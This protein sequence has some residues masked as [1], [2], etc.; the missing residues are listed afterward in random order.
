M[1][2]Q[3]RCSVFV[4]IGRRATH[5][6]HRGVVEQPFSFEYKWS[7]TWAGVGRRR[8]NHAVAARIDEAQIVRQTI[9]VDV[10]ES[11][12]G[13]SRRYPAGD[14]IQ[15]WIDR[16]DRLVRKSRDFRQRTLT[17]LKTAR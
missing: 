9:A 8:D 4:E 2:Q 13:A 7:I 10:V 17:K 3:V 11:H 14:T 15:T 5:R 16:S 6:R 12:S 1:D